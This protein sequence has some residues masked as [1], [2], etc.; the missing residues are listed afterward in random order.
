MAVV[1]VIA[2][3]L[4]N[5][6]VYALVTLGFVLIYNGSGA[7]NFAQGQLV[8]ASGM[9]VAWLTSTVALSY[10]L[11]L[12]LVVIGMG[13]LGWAFYRVAFYPL[14][15]QPI[16]AVFVSTIGMAVGIE[17]L[18]LVVWGPAPMIVQSAMVQGVHVLGATIAPQ[19]LIVFATTAAVL[20]LFYLMMGYT[21]IGRGLRATAEDPETAELVGVP[22]TRSVGY[23]FMLG[24]GLAAL[25]GGLFA[26]FVFVTPSQ[27]NQFIL[28]A[29]VAAVVG[30][31]GSPTGAVVG[32]ILVGLA[33]AFVGVYV[34][35]SYQEAIVFAAIIALLYF[36]PQGIFGEKVAAK[37]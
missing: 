25:A 23:L 21:K 27:G 34:T 28:M 35:S 7:V 13:M 16:D 32:A 33:E 9:L 36:R 5:G 8:I 20:V 22:T 29:F 30:G 37:A 6:C 4:A 2:S 10:G 3:G 18:S 15:N 11:S 19:L 24:I 12:P 26:P 14:R 31:F 1:Q 17:N